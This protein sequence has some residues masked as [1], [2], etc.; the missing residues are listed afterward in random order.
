MLCIFLY[1]TV[2][3]LKTNIK[4]QMNLKEIPEGG[5]LRIDDDDKGLF[6]PR[7]SQDLYFSLFFDVKN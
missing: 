4:S 6:P 7:E 5:R 3:E 1:Q 2:A